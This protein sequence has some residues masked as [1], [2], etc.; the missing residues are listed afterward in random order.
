MQCAYNVTDGMGREALEI[1]MD[2]SAAHRRNRFHMPS[3]EIVSIEGFDSG[4]CEVLMFTQC[5]FLS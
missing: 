5:D 4:I 2:V 1:R 3:L